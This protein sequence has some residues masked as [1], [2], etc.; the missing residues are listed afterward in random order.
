[1]MNNRMEIGSEFW[2]IPLAE[3]NGLFPDNTNWFISGRS[4]LKAILAENDFKT[5]A[6]PSWCCDS[7]IRPFIEAGIRVFFYEKAPK[8]ADAALV[9]DYFGYSSDISYDGYSGTVIRDVTHS[10][11]SRQYDDADY[12]FGSL[13]KWA[14]FLTGGF[15]WGLRK[16]VE[17]LEDDTQYICLRKK[18]MNMKADYMRGMT[19]EKSYLSVYESAECIL[20]D[21]G[22]LPADDSDIE[23]ARRFDVENVKIRR[24]KNAALLLESLGDFAIFP[25]IDPNDCPM[26][27]P[28]RVKDRN[29]L[30]KFLIQ[31]QIY[32]PV[33]WP[34]SQLHR[35]SSAEHELYNEEL[36][37]VCDQRYSEKDMKR[38][39]DVIHSF[40]RQ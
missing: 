4:A 2:D 39:I 29:E 40:Y 38:V 27:V 31:Q 19:D 13:R 28:V 33:H 15:A 34:I 25:D 1:M 21:V 5:A 11:F 9:M 30:R 14:G 17:Y 36:S 3:Q 26:F 22:I 12:Y 37:L 10:L 8:E 18:A 24:R 23:A 7:M 16:K 35:L 6:I 32:C 20:E